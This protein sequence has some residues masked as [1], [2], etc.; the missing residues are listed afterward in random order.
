MNATQISAMR[1]EALRYALKEGEAS[2]V[3]SRS[4]RDIFEAA[5]QRFEEGHGLPAQGEASSPRECF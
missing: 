1:L 4:M 2:S 3:G 5:R